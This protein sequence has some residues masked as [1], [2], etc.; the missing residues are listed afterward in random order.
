ML[1]KS[2]IKNIVRT[3]VEEKKPRPVVGAAQAAATQKRVTQNVRAA[4]D[5]ALPAD[6]E[7]KAMKELH[8]I[9]SD[10]HHKLSVLFT[11]SETPNSVKR[12]DRE[13][14]LRSHIGRAIENLE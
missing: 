14:R 6:A 2:Q 8:S 9:L 7:E 11:H 1:D 10:A 12:K 13:L 4:K 3:I 5:K